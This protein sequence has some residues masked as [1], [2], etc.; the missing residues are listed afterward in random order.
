MPIEIG[1][2]NHKAAVVNFFGDVLVKPFEF[3]NKQH[4]LKFFLKKVKT[5]AKSASSKKIFLGCGHYHLNLVY[6]IQQS[7]LLVEVINP[8]DT[9]KENPNKDAKTDKIDLL[10]RYLLLVQR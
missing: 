8:P 6:H 9:R 10:P 5:A 4:E 3:A 7:G 1:K 2:F